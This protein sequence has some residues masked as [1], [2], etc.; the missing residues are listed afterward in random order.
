M[1]ICKY[2]MIFLINIICITNNAFAESIA[3]N[4]IINTNKVIVKKIEALWN[5]V[6][7]FFKGNTIIIGIVILLVVLFIIKNKFFHKDKSPKTTIITK[8]TIERMLNISEL[9]T[10]EYPFESI[11][12][13]YKEDKIKGGK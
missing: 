4:S 13:V 5:L 7:N 12:T 6:I 11:A 9:A 3:T 8:S 2:F 10:I 1:K